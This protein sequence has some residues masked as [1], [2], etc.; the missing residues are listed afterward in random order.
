MN[1]KQYEHFL[2]MNVGLVKYGVC[3]GFSILCFFF[4]FSL[5]Y[6]VVLLLAFVVL[7]LVCQYYTKR[8]AGKKNVS[9][10]SYSVSSGT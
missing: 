5:D 4:W 10:M 1:R 9:E 8:L 3:L 2:K 6:F 7:G